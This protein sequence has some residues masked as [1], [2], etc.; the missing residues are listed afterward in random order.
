MAKKK[1]ASTKRRDSNVVTGI[2]ENGEPVTVVL[3]PPPRGKIDPKLIRAAVIKV[4]NERL[5]AR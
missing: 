4:R 2:G 5:K 3:V 1:K